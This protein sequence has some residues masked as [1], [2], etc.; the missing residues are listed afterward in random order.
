MTNVI[1]FL[2]VFANLFFEMT[3]YIML[4]L[5]FVGFLHIFITKDMII[6]H[7]GKDN[8]WSVAKAS[9][10]GIPLPLCSCGVVPSAVYLSKNGA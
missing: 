1:D 7:I 10:L 5:L 3:F 8:L 4:G 6:K 2:I 9:I